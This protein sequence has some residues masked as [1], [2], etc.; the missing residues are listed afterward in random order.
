MLP[1]TPRFGTKIVLL[2]GSRISDKQLINVS[3]TDLSD[4]IGFMDKQY[5]A[6]GR[7]SRLGRICQS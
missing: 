5:I 2:I 7:F 1:G 3:P 4:P 6:R